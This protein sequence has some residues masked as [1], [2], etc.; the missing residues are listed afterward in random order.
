MV[1]FLILGSSGL[2][3]R[4]VTRDL[5]ENGYSVA[6]ADMYK[7]GS[8]KNLERSRSAKFHFIDLEDQKA[9]ERL[10]KSVK[11]K[12][13]VNCAEGDWN[14]HVYKAC[15]ATKV[16]VLD[17]GSDIPMTKKQLDMNVDFSKAGLTA[18]TGCGS[19]PGI[20]NVM[21]CHATH[22]FSH[23]ET[24]EA[25]FAWDS[26]IKKFVVPF[27]IASIM[28]E[29]TDPAATLVEGEM[30]DVTPLETEEI[31]H[32][33][34]IGK[35]RSYIVRHPE[36]YSFYKNYEANGV[37]NIRFYA[38]FP[39]HSL[40]ALF[41]F[42]ELGFADY[43]PEVEINGHKVAPVDALTRLLQRTHPPKG[44]TETENLWIKVIGTNLDGK[45]QTTHME[46]IVPTLP[47][48]EDAGCNID[49]GFPASIMAQMV[50]D[51]RI[52]AR[53]SFTPTLVV[54]DDAF[55]REIAGRGMTIYKNDQVL[56]SPKKHP[57]TPGRHKKKVAATRAR[58]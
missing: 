11:P 34:A 39:D 57:R 24:I 56:Y 42:M 35:Q 4:I 58:K 3:G 2:Q 12:V 27:S 6:L 25:G 15:L 13:V 52:D 55:F 22:D 51:G 38:G 50:L 31:R 37:R 49:T 17:L 5:I 32:Y 33:R 53:G 10:I 8:L 28:E 20:N 43:E 26:N 21:L 14:L 44:Y 41:N 54:P 23:I 40:A 29:L 7:E 18:I 48:W 30:I 36:T 9:T 1:E 16:H 19:T 47:G 45:S 46:C